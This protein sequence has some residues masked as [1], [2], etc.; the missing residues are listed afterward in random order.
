M[1]KS[2]ETEFQ[3]GLP[4]VTSSSG[5]KDM[6]DDF[7]GEELALHTPWVRW[8][9][10]L[11][12]TGEIV[13]HFVKNGDYGARENVQLLLTAPVQFAN[14]DGEEVMVGEG[15]YLNIG[16]SAGNKAVSHLP[17]GTKV[18]IDCIGQTDMGRGKKK[19][20]DFKVRYKR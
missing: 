6:R 2:K 10:G 17:V 3:E 20:W 9:V 19:A 13:M 8:F 12:V 4:D 14:S 16:L 11:S 18:K 7:G 1:A 15:E 5:A